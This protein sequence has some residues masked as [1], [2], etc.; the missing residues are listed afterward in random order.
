[1][2]KVIFR[3]KRFRNGGIERLIVDIL[4]NSKYFDI[5]F[6]LMIEEKEEWEI[7]K[8]LENKI[9][10]IYLKSSGLI[11]IMNNLKSKKGVYFIIFNCLKI[12][13]KIV[14]IKKINSYILENKINIFIDYSGEPDKY[15]SKIKAPKKI[16]WNHISISQ[17]SKR[18]IEIY[19]KRLRNYDYL[20]TICDE[21][22][23]EFKMF[24]PELKEKI[25]KIYNFIDYESIDNKIKNPILDEKEKKLLKEDYCLSIG[26]LSE[27][28]DYKTIIRA[29]EILK[30]KGVNKKLFIIGEGEDRRKIEIFIKEKNL[31]NQ[32]FLLGQKDNPYIW[33][34]NADIFIHAARLEGFGL[35]LVEAMYC[36]IPIISSQY[37]CG[38]REILENGKN[39]ELFEVGNYKELALK[40]EN[41]LNNE[42]KRKQYISNSLKGIER[43]SIKRIFEEYK[44][45]IF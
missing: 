8:F 33:L 37:R 25:L 5:E 38:A 19:R 27:I 32:I 1:M 11:D 29:F 15:I 30:Q 31:S 12:Y 21:M 35:V 14:L 43:F 44:K 7:E 20:V 28:K 26:R 9:E 18:G 23:E 40:I 22:K 10:I 16:I 41:L 4:N 42:L 17:K 39:G 34:K 2:K 3:L 45:I 24:F 13:E 6:I 36:Q